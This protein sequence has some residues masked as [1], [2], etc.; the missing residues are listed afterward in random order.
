MR[1]LRRSP[2]HDNRPAPFWWVRLFNE[3]PCLSHRF[4]HAPE[5]TGPHALA[6]LR[7]PRRSQPRSAPLCVPPHCVWLRLSDACRQRE[8]ILHAPLRLQVSTRRCFRSIL[9]DARQT[10]HPRLPALWSKGNQHV[11]SHRALETQF[12]ADANSRCHQ[13]HRGNAPGGQFPYRHSHWAPP[14]TAILHQPTAPETA[15]SLAGSLSNS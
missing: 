2:N 1:T 13:R 6:P 12:R 8:E 3:M 14:V 7:D 4:R 15:S 9:Y 5:L 10:G 11:A